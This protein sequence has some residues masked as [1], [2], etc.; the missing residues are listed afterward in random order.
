MFFLLWTVF[1]ALSLL[2]VLFF[3]LSQRAVMTQAYKSEAVHE[4]REKSVHIKRAVEQD[5][6]PEFENNKSLYL[7]M[8]STSYDVNIFILDGDGEVLFPLLRTS[9]RSRS[10]PDRKVHGPH[11]G[12]GNR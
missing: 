1:T 12:N 5:V 10:T 3:G 7:R 11:R 2:I 9:R 6:P 8:L 4:L